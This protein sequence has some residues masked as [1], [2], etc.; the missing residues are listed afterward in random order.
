M[1]EKLGIPTKTKNFQSQFVFQ[2]FLF[3]LNFIIEDFN[4]HCVKIKLTIITKYR[5]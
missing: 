5:Q 3:Q 2:K 4:L 1:C